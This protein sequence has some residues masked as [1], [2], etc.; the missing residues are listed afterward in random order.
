[1]RNTV[2]ISLIFTSFQLFSQVKEEIKLGD[3][4]A[5]YF[6]VEE[7]PEFSDGNAGIIKFITDNFDYSK[8]NSS[9]RILVR[10][11]VNFRGEVEKVEIIRGINEETDNEAIRVIKKMPKWKPG[12]Q[13]GKLVNVWFTIPISFN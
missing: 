10:F 11:V 4:S 3:T 1:M 7:M 5:I 13:F 8:V 12:K 9:G 6:V 2:F